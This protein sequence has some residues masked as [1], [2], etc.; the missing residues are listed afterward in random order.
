M[1]FG[2]MDLVGMM[3]VMLGQRTDMITLLAGV[4]ETFYR[5][6]LAYGSTSWSTRRASNKV[7]RF[8]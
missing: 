5:S 8:L 2:K 1:Q 3:Q 6:C 4:D 7:S